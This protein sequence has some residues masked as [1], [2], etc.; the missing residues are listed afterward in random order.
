MIDRQYLVVK[1]VYFSVRSRHSEQD[2]RTVVRHRIRVC[3]HAYEV[4]LSIGQSAT[5]QDFV[6]HDFLLVRCGGG[7]GRVFLCGV[8]VSQA[9]VNGGRPHKC[10]HKCVVACTQSMLLSS[11]LER[12][13]HP[14]Y[15]HVWDACT[16]LVRCCFFRL[17]I[18]MHGARMTSSR[19][20]TMRTSIR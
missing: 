1:Y 17:S 20:S 3:G 18:G 8:A 6:P 5:E 13:A 9:Y 12:K 11:L 14:S 4:Q 2:R 7:G 19:T 15:A 16:R 10:V